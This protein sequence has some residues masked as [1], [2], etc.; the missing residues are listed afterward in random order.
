MYLFSFCEEGS[1]NQILLVPSDFINSVSEWVKPHPSL[2]LLYE[3]SLSN[4]N[5]FRL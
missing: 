1:K 3:N 5:V 4:S 2:L